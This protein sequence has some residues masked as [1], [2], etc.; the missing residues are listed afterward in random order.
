[1]RRILM[2]ALVICAGITFT[3]S[4]VASAQS[5]DCCWGPGCPNQPGA[6]AASIHAAET[7]E[8]RCLNTSQQYA[9]QMGFCEEFGWRSPSWVQLDCDLAACHFQGTMKCPL[10]GGGFAYPSYQMDCP[11]QSGQLP[12]AGG[13]FGTAQCLFPNGIEKI[14]SCSSD[15]YSVLVL[16]Q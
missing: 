12:V 14:A 9:P 16:S 4:R 6:A 1:M 5:D 11:A 2:A 13:G 3:G 15:G 10:P 7:P 8:L